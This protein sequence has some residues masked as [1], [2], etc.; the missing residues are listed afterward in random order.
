[1]VLLVERD[2]EKLSN[3]DKEVICKKKQAT[4][5][6]FLKVMIFS[7]IYTLLWIYPLFSKKR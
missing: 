6:V 4:R 7:C 1:M 2:M 5:P 3:V